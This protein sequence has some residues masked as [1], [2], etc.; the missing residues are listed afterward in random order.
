M[1]VSWYKNKG[2]WK[3][4]TCNLVTSQTYVQYCWEWGELVIRSNLS[5]VIITLTKVL[6]I[7]YICSVIDWM[8]LTY[9]WDAICHDDFQDF[10]FFFSFKIF[11]LTM[12]TIIFSRAAFCCLAESVENSWYQLSLDHLSIYV[13]TAIRPDC[14]YLTEFTCEVWRKKSEYLKFCFRQTVL[15]NKSYLCLDFLDFFSLVRLNFLKNW[16]KTLIYRSRALL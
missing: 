10:Y 13:L 12:P 9:L 7:V 4:F 8:L 1:W 15:P 11:R 16:D 2:F 3:R 6:P 5:I 14:Y